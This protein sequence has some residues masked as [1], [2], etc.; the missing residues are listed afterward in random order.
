LLLSLALAPAPFGILLAADRYTLTQSTALACLALSFALLSAPRFSGQ[1]AQSA[2]AHASAIFASVAFL[3]ALSSASLRSETL[4]VAA[5]AAWPF[6]LY[7]CAQLARRRSAAQLTAPFV[8]IAD[9][10]FIL[11]FM[12][13]S[14]LALILHVDRTLVTLRTP[15]FC[16]L[17]A[18]ILY[19]S[20]RAARERSAFGA[21][22][23][24]LAALVIAAAMLDALKLAGLWPA[25]WPIAAGVICAAFL[26]R[27]AAPGLLE[28]KREGLAFDARPLRG[29]VH[30]VT[31][32]AVIACATLWFATALYRINEGGGG[33][34][35][36]LSLALLYWFE[37]AAQ[38]RLASIAH[39][40]SIHAGELFIAL[41]VALRIDAQWFAAAAALILFPLFFAAAHYYGAR[42]Q[43]DALWFAAPAST[44]A[45]V[46]I[47]LAF[48]LA[49]LHAAPHLRPG[50]P[51]LLAPLISSGAIA[52]ACFC[53]SFLSAPETRVRYFRAGLFATVVSFALGCLRAGYDPVSD[54]EI[55]SSPLAVLLLAIAYLSA[56]RSWEEYDLDT[57]L[58]LWIGSLLLSMPLLFHALYF[59]LL[60][61]VPALTRDLGTL[62]AALALILF[63]ALGRFRAPVLVGGVAL[64]LELAALALTSVDWLQIR[65]RNY[66]MTVGALIVLVVWAFEYRREQIMLARKRFKEHSDYARE[67]FG[68]WR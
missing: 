41:L 2:L 23:L 30:F 54:I 52:L 25:S 62:C 12:W 55:Y 8:R 37:R 34:A 38:S 61:D 60:L 48:I 13:A 6:A 3:I 49:M 22:L 29:I 19:G 56:R 20:L 27:K 31:D 7:T 45:V 21:A 28:R 4:Y 17:L 65:L 50:D 64:A 47:A 16:A 14:V 42:G 26:I 68:E 53:A 5:C 9:A 10:E 39:L 24:S 33:A 51:S 11:L 36:V 15:M 32:L 58:L 44:A 66:L 40:A 63:G 67:R 35:F 59:R 1:V 57:S 18:A 43:R 46:T